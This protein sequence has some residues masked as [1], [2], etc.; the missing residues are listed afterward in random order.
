MSYG[1]ILFDNFIGQ[2]VRWIIILFDGQLITKMEALQYNVILSID[3]SACGFQFFVY[4]SVLYFYYRLAL[5]YVMLYCE[6]TY[7]V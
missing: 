4:I 2:A 5:F 3:Q 7:D 6:T 1:C